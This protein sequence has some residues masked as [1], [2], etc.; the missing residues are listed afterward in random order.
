[1][2][3]LE[4][5]RKG[6]TYNCL[7]QEL[8]A[9]RGQTF[10]ALFKF[11]H[12]ADSEKRAALLKQAGALVPNSSYIAPPLEMSYGCHLSMGENSYINSGALI[13]D[14]GKVTI[15]RHVMIGPRVQIYTRHSPPYSGINFLVR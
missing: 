1:M 4:K 10:A 15:G 3:E 6:Q 9:I 12:E 7:D 5:M 13:L 11:N 14:N 8:A 2:S